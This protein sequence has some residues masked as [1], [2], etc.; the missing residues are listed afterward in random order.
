[1]SFGFVW[2]LLDLVFGILGGASTGSWR[3]G[4]KIFQRFH[5]GSK[6]QARRLIP[7]REWQ[8]SSFRIGV[9]PHRTLHRVCL[10]CLLLTRADCQSRRSRSTSSVHQHRRSCKRDRSGARHRA[11]QILLPI[12]PSARPV[13]FEPA[14]DHICPLSKKAE[15]FPRNDGN[16]RCNEPQPH[17]TSRPVHRQRSACWLMAVLGAPF[18]PNSTEPVLPRG[19]GMPYGL[20]WWYFW[21]LIVIVALVYGWFGRKRR[22]EPFV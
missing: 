8:P 20:S 19:I 14:F 1:M 21:S 17:E 16:V 9:R 18:R 15:C 10:Q 4:P 7:D 22:G 2:F 6:G 5:Q 12:R 3:T 11:Q 13:E